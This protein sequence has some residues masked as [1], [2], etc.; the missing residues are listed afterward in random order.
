M[1]LF[2]KVLGINSNVEG[3]DIVDIFKY[4]MREN[5]RFYDMF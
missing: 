3:E 4:M 5:R 1:L 2:N